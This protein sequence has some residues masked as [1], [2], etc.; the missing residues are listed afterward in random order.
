MSLDNPQ[1]TLSTEHWSHAYIIWLLSA[2]AF[3]LHHHCLIHHLFGYKLNSKAQSYSCRC[4]ARPLQPLT[5]DLLIS[6]CQRCLLLQLPLPPPFDTF[7]LRKISIY[8]FIKRRLVLAEESSSL[9]G[10]FSAN[11]TVSPL[12]INGQCLWLNNFSVNKQSLWNCWQHLSSI[13][14][15]NSF[16]LLFRFWAESHLTDGYLQTWG[17]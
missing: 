2:V 16:S 9:L 6:Y 7:D 3:M 12:A 17:K 4:W 1:N 8:V 15:T 10:C 11:W 5:I 13:C 14:G